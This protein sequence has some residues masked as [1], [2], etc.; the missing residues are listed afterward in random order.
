MKVVQKDEALGEEWSK[1]RRLTCGKRRWRN[2]TGTIGGLLSGRARHLLWKRE[3]QPPE[4]S[5][6]CSPTSELLPRAAAKRLRRE[7]RL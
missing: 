5:G 2:I 7:A 4:R 6:L 3:W 1:V